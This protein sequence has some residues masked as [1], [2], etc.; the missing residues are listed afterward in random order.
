MERDADAVA[1]KLVVVDG[2]RGKSHRGGKQTDHA[3]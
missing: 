2:V 3:G 1:Q